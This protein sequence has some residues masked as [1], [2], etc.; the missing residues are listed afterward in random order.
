[1]I[2]CSQTVAVLHINRSSA[3]RNVAKD[4]SIPF[5]LISFYICH[6]IITVWFTIRKDREVMEL[7]EKIYK[8]TGFERRFIRTACTFLIL[9]LLYTV[10]ASTFVSGNKTNEK[11]MIHT[12]SVQST[13]T[14]EIKKESSVAVSSNE[15]MKN[16]QASAGGTETSVTAG[17]PVIEPAVI[18]PYMPAIEKEQT[19]SV[20]ET[21]YEKENLNETPSVSVTPAQPAAPVQENITVESEVPSYPQVLPDT[22]DTADVPSAPAA[23]LPDDGMLQTSDDTTVQGFYIDEKGMITGISDTAE[24]TD[25]ILALPEQGCT[26]VRKGAFLNAPAGIREIHIPAGIVQIEEG[27]FTGL[28]SLERIE[29]EEN[30][31]YFTEE[32]ILFS[33][34]GSCLLC[35]PA[36]RT[37]GY[38][39]PEHVKKFAQDAFSGA[40]ISILDLSLCG[41]IDTGNLP[42]YIKLMPSIEETE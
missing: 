42:E 27:A 23:P 12:S 36:A 8:G 14:E 41:Q 4:C 18:I 1:M 9:I 20:Q 34:N 24:I 6:E 39:V 31:V 13:E 29:T 40:Q 19:V 37:G 35:F 17:L 28:Y 5:S 33:E 16:G 15:N 7:C 38:I 21:Y 25:G 22:E 11:D 3:Q 10:A 2:F 26:G 30:S 32:G